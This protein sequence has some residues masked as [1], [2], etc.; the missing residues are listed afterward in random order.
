[1][2]CNESHS[3][4]YARVASCILNTMEHNVRLCVCLIHILTE[5]EKER[6][7][8]HRYAENVSCGI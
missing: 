8:V 7:S 3:E 1:M 5:R 6:V 2:L 4:L